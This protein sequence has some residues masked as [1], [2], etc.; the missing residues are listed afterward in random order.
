MRVLIVE[1]DPMSALILRKTLEQ[2]GHEALGAAN[3][4]EA[5]ELIQ[6]EDIRLVISDW[7]MPQMDGLELCRRIR[8]RRHQAYTYVIVVTA[9]RQRKDR[10][11]ALHAGADDLLSKPFDQGELLARTQVAQRIL[12]M[13]EELQT[14]W[15][16]LSAMRDEL[17]CQNRRLAEM[18][19]CDGLTG[20]KNHRH[21]REVLDASYSLALRQKL[22]LSLVMLDVDGF[23]AYND[24]FGHPAGDAV[25]SDLADILLEHSR[26]HDLVARYGGEEFVMLLMGT[27][28][29]GASLVCERM[30]SI[31]ARHNWPL[32]PIT[33]SFGASTLV[34][35]TLN[36]EQ[37]V[38]E[39][40]QA[41]YHSKRC[42]RNRVT[43]FQDLVAAAAAP[44]S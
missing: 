3:G 1:D 24:T 29:Q 26:E 12:V 8:S 28:T 20:L 34:P 37:L 39:A 16:E 9:K 14:R 21:F 44:L 18:A 32:R 17:E 19:V 13:Q 4:V 25:L 38:K 27:E 43:H 40:D 31:I 42:G 11:E 6:R 35:A 15:R 5:W 2:M 30:R 22:P 36:T 10:V 33:A 7:M 41:L 23:K